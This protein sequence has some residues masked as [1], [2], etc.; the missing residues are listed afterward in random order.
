MEETQLFPQHF[1]FGKRRL[2]HPR[3]V[4]QLLPHIV[5]ISL[6]S[7][8]FDRPVPPELLDR[9]SALSLSPILSDSVLA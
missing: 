7:L 3:Q 4:M 1:H 6:E 9:I 2:P 5:I 8:E